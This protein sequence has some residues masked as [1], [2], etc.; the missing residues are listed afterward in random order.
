MRRGQADEIN[1]I[2]TLCVPK[3]V[4]SARAVY[5]PYPPGPGLG[6]FL[7]PLADAAYYFAVVIR[8]AFYV[9]GFNV[10][11]ALDRLGQPH[12]KWLDWRALATTLIAPKTETISRIAICTAVRTDDL[13]KQLRHRA[14]LKALRA[15]QIHCLT[16]HF[17]REKRNCKRCGNAWHAPVEKQ[18]DVNLAIAVI[19]DAHRDIFDRAYI[20]T[21][22]GDQAAT[23]GLLQSRFPE[24]DIVSVILP[25]QN[26]NQAILDRGARPRKLRVAQLSRSLLPE[27][28]AG[29][30]RPAEYDPP[31]PQN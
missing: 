15:R 23:I 22:D 31:L 16:G 24:K 1:L 6:G 9:D 19:D 3:W 29:V 21:A 12:L 25:G 11:H 8:S 28:I 20:V 5:R 18:G 2:L 14:Y 30:T 10:Y 4:Q 27:T 26:H 7:L 17:A 13:G